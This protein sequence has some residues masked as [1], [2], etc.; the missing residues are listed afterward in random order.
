MRDVESVARESD[1]EIYPIGIADTVSIVRGNSI[2]PQ[3]WLCWVSLAKQGGGR[4]Y[5]VDNA[6]ELPTVAENIGLELRNQYVS[7]YVPR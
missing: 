3:V 4:V 2:R 7:G 6:H 1:V 5:E